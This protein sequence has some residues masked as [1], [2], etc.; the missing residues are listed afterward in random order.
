MK[1]RHARIFILVL[2]MLVG[3]RSL[4]RPQAQAAGKLKVVTATQDLASIVQAVGGDKV[5][6]FS[7]STGNQ[8]PHFVPPKPSY[9]LKL[10]DADLLVRTGMELDI[11]LDPLIESAR[12]Q[13]IFRNG[14]AYVDASQNVPVLGA[15]ANR[16]DRSMGD[17][18]S[19]GNPHYW[20][21][22]VNAKYI[23]LN[24]VNGLKRVD[25]ADAAYFEQHRQAFLKSLASKLTGWLKESKP[26][27]GVP[28]IT[29]HDSWPY[30]T[31]RFG[32]DVVGHIEP[33]PG[34][35][36]SPKYLAQLIGKVKAQHVKLIIMEPYFN[37]SAPDTIAKATGAKV[38]VLAPSVGGAPDI[39]NYLQLFDYQLNT[40]LKNI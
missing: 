12:N 35:P 4:S 36:P 11:W 18:H 13:K 33:L 1:P 31:Q 40:L 5:D 9:I 38:V 16:Q 19:S 3:M 15:P 22:P 39:V 6:V 7:I 8:N 27:M 28:V 25:P 20:L 26:L 29:Y 24:I 10:K 32:L 37:R 23:S 21:D 34:I 14:S 2:L 30:F 17:V